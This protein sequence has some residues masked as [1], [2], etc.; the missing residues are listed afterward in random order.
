MTSENPWKQ[1]DAYRTKWQ[2]QLQA[3]GSA[4]RDVG[5]ELVDVQSDGIITR[6]RVKPRPGQA[7]HL[8]RGSFEVRSLEEALERLK[9]P[10]GRS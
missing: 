1:I 6:Y 9:P 2:R 4:L 5:G 3:F 10:E 8:P 7:K